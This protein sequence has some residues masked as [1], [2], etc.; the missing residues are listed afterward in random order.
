MKFI[1]RILRY[2]CNNTEEVGITTEKIICKIVNTV[3]KT[4]RGN[5]DENVYKEIENDIRMTIGDRLVRKGRWEHI[6]NENKDSD[7]RVSG[8]TISIKTNISGDKICPQRI[9]QQTLNTFNKYFKECIRTNDEFKV[10][11]MNNIER[12]LEEYIRNVFICDETIC[13][14]YNEGIIYEITRETEI[15][16]R[17]GITRTTRS[18]EEWNESNTIRRE[19]SNELVTIGEIQIHKNR[20][21]L[22]FRFSLKG[23]LRMIKE[24]EIEGIR[25][26]EHRMENKYIFKVRKEGNDDMDKMEIE[27]R[28]PST[29]NYIGSK[30]KLLEFI[31]GTMEEYSGRKIGS[32]D[33]VMDCFSGTG[34][35]GYYLL[36]NG[37][38]RVI[39][40][41]IQRYAAIVSAV[42][43]TKGIDKCK[44]ERVIKDI[45]ENI[46]NMKE[47]DINENG[48]VVR[49]YTESGGRMYFT[50]MNGWIID[51][52]RQEIERMREKGYITV[53]EYKLLI[54]V[55]LYG[56]NKVGNIA[57]V[58]G[59]YL[60]QWKEVAKRRIEMD[61]GIIGWLL[62]R[63]EQETYN[64]N[65]L[66]LMERIRWEEVDVAYI[67]S[68]YN[69][70]GYED[71]YHVLESI[72]RYDNMEVKGK[73]GLRKE[74]KEGA[75]IF[76]SKRNVEEGFE[77]L[78][79]GVR[80]KYIYISYSS[81]GLIS[82]KRMM[83][84]MEGG[85]WGR[86]QCKE[87]EYKKFKSNGEGN[88]KRI[89]EYIFC[90]E[91]P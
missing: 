76:T 63:G 49:N 70:R 59:A 36:Q 42:W 5:T 50:R 17:E 28:R 65:I 64:E 53:E 6:G 75:R 38:R 91:R 21:G 88:G 4:K 22:K 39:S 73:T 74:N 2:N 87:K 23:I 10:Y 79:K 57:S 80:S 81:D 3:F 33:T 25:V 15:R 89:L 47:C 77:K 51:E 16:I 86:I 90:G 82:K 52:I 14:L 84:I 9:G 85:G 32:I 40:N 20:N 61:E 29:F 44:M 60:K 26:I 7:F 35:V 46:K 58:Y 13:I 69:T 19:I 54:K 67:D 45:N 31:G 62:E 43:T 1:E 66:K 37:V 11:F 71:N 8:R 56:V 41:D 30:T 24:G 48:Y 55:L 72:A 18:I 27:I 78:V 83:E 34:V 68:P 12:L